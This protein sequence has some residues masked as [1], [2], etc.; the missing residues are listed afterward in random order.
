MPVRFSLLFRK[1]RYLSQIGSGQQDVFWNIDAA[2]TFV[3]VCVCVW[4]FGFG[5]FVGFAM[6]CLR[7]ESGRGLETIPWG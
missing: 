3:V 4:E 5:L 7:R 6:L 1:K 2:G